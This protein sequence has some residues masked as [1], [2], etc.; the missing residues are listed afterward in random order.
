MKALQQPIFF[1]SILH[2]IF[3]EAYII[4]A[5]IMQLVAVSESVHTNSGLDLQELQEIPLSELLE[6]SQEALLHQMQLE[7]NQVYADQQMGVASIIYHHEIQLKILHIHTEENHY[8][9][10]IKNDASSKEAIAKALRES[11]LR[12]Q[13]IVSNTPGLVCQFQLDAEGDI[14]FVY[15]SDRCNELLGFSPDELKLNSRLFYEMMNPRDKTLLKMRL[16]YSRSELSMLNWDGRVWIKEWQDTKWINMRSIPRTLTDGTLQWEG[17]ITNITQSMQEKFEIEESRRRLAE[18]TTHM[19]DIKEAERHKISCEIHDDLGGNLTAIKIGL[20]SIMQR[21]SHG[22]EVTMEKLT[23]LDEIVDST[24]DAIHR[25]SSDLR[26]NILNLGIVAALDWQSREFEKQFGIP[27]L[28]A[29]S[30]PD[31]SVLPDQ[32]MALFRI[33][34]EAMSNIAKYAKATEVTVHLNK[35]PNEVEMLIAD[36]GI[37]IKPSDKLKDNSFGLRGMQERV[38]ALNGNFKISRLRGEKQGTLVSVKLP[39]VVA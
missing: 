29:V 1:Q 27:C 30:E 20:S 38:S 2:G 36:N 31:I 5:S 3:D 18:L 8:L 33:C 21:V 25:I 23:Q 26:P 6:I 35:L 15:L 12:F 16:K 34:Q 14:Q 32:A 28:F 7:G 13:A 10:V 37:G 24:Y 17:F 39:A 22:Q 9:L 4:D 19:N 11:E